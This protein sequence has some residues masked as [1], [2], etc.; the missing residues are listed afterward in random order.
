[1]FALTVGTLVRESGDVTG[2]GGVEPNDR[3]RG[4]DL[5]AYEADAT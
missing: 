2:T 5:L 3:L 4:T 1:M